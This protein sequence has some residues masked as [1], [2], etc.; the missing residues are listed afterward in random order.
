[1][2][3]HLL[4]IF[5]GFAFAAT[6]PMLAQNGPPPTFTELLQQHHVALTKTGLLDALRSPEAE[7]RDLA[8]AKLAEDKTEDAIPAITQALAAEYVSGTKVNIAFALAQLGNE[9]GTST[10]KETCHK[11]EINQGL[12]VRAALYMLDLKSNACLPDVLDLLQS[13]DEDDAGYR[14]EALSLVPRFK[15]VS[16]D[17]SQELL[18][19]TLRS[20]EDATPAVRMSASDALARLRDATAIPYLRSAIAAE[21]D[22]VVRAQMETALQWLQRKK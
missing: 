22:E 16:K 19:I 14:M 21:Q 13:Q 3:F 10:L 20:L 4:S 2:S 12:R 11:S 7:V 17:D 8:A 15:D 6:T 18:A 9:V 5:L 1:M